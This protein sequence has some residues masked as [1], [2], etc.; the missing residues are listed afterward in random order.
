MFLWYIDDSSSYNLLYQIKPIIY[1]NINQTLMADMSMFSIGLP[2]CLSR[3][4]LESLNNNWCK[5]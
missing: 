1:L 2:A 5:I 3:I 4:C